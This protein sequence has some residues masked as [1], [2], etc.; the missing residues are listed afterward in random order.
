MIS[1]K[2][3]IK[4]ILPHY[5]CFS[6]ITIA[7]KGCPDNEL[8]AISLR[9]QKPTKGESRKGC[10]RIL[11]LILA[12]PRYYAPLLKERSAANAIAYRNLPQ[13]M[14]LLGLSVMHASSEGE[15]LA[16]VSYS[17]TT[18]QERYTYKRE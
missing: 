15:R 13:S 8:V 4:P 5:F 17:S 16:K 3:P 12:K 2:T 18:S 9:A 11:F 6:V 14:E 10:A 1:F 7:I